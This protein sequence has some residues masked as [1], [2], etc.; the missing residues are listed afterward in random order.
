VIDA[1]S[2]QREAFGSRAAKEDPKLRATA[3][4]LSKHIEAG[5]VG[6][7]E[8]RDDLLDA[9]AKRYRKPVYG[10]ALVTHSLESID[11]PNDV[12]TSK[13]LPVAVVVAPYTKKGHPWTM[14]AV[15]VVFPRQPKA[16][17]ASLD[18]LESSTSAKNTAGRR[19]R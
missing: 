1:L 13:N 7:L 2:E 17:I 16:N 10:Y 9:A 8:A 3:R 5:N 14:Y 12:L 4:K 19:S 18:G 6:I 15:I 11:F